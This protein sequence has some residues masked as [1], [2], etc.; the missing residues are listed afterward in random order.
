MIYKWTRSTYKSSRGK[1]QSR[2]YEYEKIISGT[3]SICGKGLKRKVNRL[4]GKVETLD[5]FKKR[6]TC[7]RYQ[8]K[9][10]HWLWGDCLKISQTGEGNS[11]YKGLMFSC[12]D[13]GKRIT[14]LS[15]K[16]QKAGMKRERCRK[17]FT[18]WAYKTGW[19]KDRAKSLEPYF[20]KKG[21]IA[22][23]KKK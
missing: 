9:L 4:N 21:Q 2:D 1:L 13:C 19:F 6:K 14:Y 22:W 7:G 3:C 17:C 23:N 10:G 20:F 18:K 12:V 8:D 5:R 16:E 11:N 15:K